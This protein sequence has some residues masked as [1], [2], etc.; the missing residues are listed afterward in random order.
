MSY[1]IKHKLYISRLHRLHIKGLRE[2]RNYC[3]FC[4]SERKMLLRVSADFFF[5]FVKTKHSPS[6]N[7][8]A[9]MPAEVQLFIVLHKHRCHTTSFHSVCQARSP[10]PLKLHLHRA[11]HIRTTQKR[12][13]CQCLTGMSRLKAALRRPCTIWSAKSSLGF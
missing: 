12:K 3:K 4:A 5:P 2:V 1:K 8:L 7:C 10:C 11:L 9:K 6:Y 13:Q